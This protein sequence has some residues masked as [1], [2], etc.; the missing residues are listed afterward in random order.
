[1]GEVAD[2]LPDRA[3]VVA[4]LRKNNL[5]VNDASIALYADAYM[6]YATAQANIA[7]HGSVVFHPRTGAPI[8]NP[9]IPIRAAASK[10]IRE[11]KLIA[12]GL[13]LDAKKS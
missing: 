7:K 5:W 4:L 2:N 10:A 9:Y 8:S 13:W 12:P 11:I 3:D 1:M 6:D